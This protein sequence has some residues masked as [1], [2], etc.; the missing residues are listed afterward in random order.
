M[1][2]AE[3]P[4]NGLPQI[5]HTFDK[6]P[7]LPI[8][9]FEAVVILGTLALLWLLSRRQP[10][11]VK[12]FFLVGL[13]GSIFEVFTA[14]MWNNEKLGVWAYLYKDVSWV[15]TMGWSS[16]ILGTVLLVDRSLPLVRGWQRFLLYLVVLTILTAVA[17]SA[18]VGLGIRSY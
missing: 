8:L 3:M 16:L 15:L 12:H 4:I 13:G 5:I 17:E 18:V 2:G 11:V 1:G 14:P 9:C 7:T 6:E 10:H